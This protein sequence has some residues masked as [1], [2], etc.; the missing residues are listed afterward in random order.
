MN[1]KINTLP[2]KERMPYF[3]RWSTATLMDEIAVA[4]EKYAKAHKTYPAAATIYELKTALYP[5]YIEEMRVEDFWGTRFRYAS[6]DGG[7]SYILVSAGSDKAFRSR[8]WSTSGVFD[9]DTEDAVIVNGKH[10]RE[11][12]LLK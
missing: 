2:E 8:S 6:L 4:L 11:W 10:V 5:D 12:K 1:E 3:W 9:S 7:T